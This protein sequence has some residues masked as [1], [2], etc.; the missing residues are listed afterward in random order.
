MKTLNTY[1]TYDSVDS[2]LL[3]KK[4]II[5][6][7][8]LSDLT[9]GEIQTKRRKGIFVTKR[10]LAKNKTLALQAKYILDSLLVMSRQNRCCK[11]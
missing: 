8:R 2:L 11:K 7:K 4:I 10:N 9:E 5:T 6:F 3:L 1:L